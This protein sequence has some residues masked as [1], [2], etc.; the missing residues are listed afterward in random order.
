MEN[1]KQILSKLCVIFF[2]VLFAKDIF[3]DTNRNPIGKSLFSR[4]D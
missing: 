3:H 4:N 1:F 2:I